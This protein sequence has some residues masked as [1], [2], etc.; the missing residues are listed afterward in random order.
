MG[1]CENDLDWLDGIA[2]CIDF[3][4]GIVVAPAT[5]AP[6]LYCD[7]SLDARDDAGSTRVVCAKDSGKLARKPLKQGRLQKKG[8]VDPSA[9]VPRKTRKRPDRKGQETRRMENCGWMKVVVGSKSYYVRGDE[10][11]TSQKEAL[12]RCR[13]AVLDD[14]TIVQLFYLI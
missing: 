13:H 5:K 7:E 8:I 2:E 3:L 10:Q 14:A 11:V 12:K 9:L 6:Y 1:D 4:D